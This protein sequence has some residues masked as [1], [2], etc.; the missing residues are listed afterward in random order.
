MSHRKIDKEATIKNI[1]EAAEGH[2]KD[3][4]AFKEL[5]KNEQDI[6]DTALLWDAEVVY[7]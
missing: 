2:I 7:L 3:M 5:M 1:L 6:I 4:E